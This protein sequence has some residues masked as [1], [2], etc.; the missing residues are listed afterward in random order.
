MGEE[1]RGQKSRFHVQDRVASGV[2]IRE[3][4]HFP[5]HQSYHQFPQC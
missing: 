5:Y 3:D 4:I 1:Q 2:L